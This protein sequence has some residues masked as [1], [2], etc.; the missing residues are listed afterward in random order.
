MRH[1]RMRLSDFPRPGDFPEIPGSHYDEMTL[2]YIDSTRLS[3][4]PGDATM[5]HPLY[6]MRPDTFLS[7]DR[8]EQLER[9]PQEDGYT[10]R[11][12]R[13]V[14]EV[15]C[16]PDDPKAPFVTTLAPQLL[17]AANRATKYFTN[18]RLEVLGTDH[19]T[20]RLIVQA[21]GQG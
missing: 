21:P 11:E 10:A 16:N 3:L 6:E 5:A 14:Y 9:Q 1:Q 7:A 13:F 17:E 8:R 2:L 18:R 15:I 12:L 4:N 19:Q 20:G